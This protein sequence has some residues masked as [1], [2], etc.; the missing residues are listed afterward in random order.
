M[1]NIVLYMLFSNLIQNYLH[2]VVLFVHVGVS[3]AFS[4]FPLSSL[5]SPSF[6]VYSSVFDYFF[7]LLGGPAHSHVPRLQQQQ[8][9]HLLQ[10]KICLGSVLQSSR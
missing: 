4:A 8:Q 3:W 1:F 6:H 9:H 5:L 10:W 7:R 2:F